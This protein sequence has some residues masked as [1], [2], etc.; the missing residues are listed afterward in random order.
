MTVVSNVVLGPAEPTDQKEPE[1]IARSP[2][3]APVRPELVQL[4]QLRLGASIAS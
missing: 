3:D 1:A 4:R 2:A